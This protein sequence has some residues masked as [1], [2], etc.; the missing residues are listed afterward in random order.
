MRFLKTEHTFKRLDLVEADKKKIQ[1]S[2]IKYTKSFYN[3]IPYKKISYSRVEFS[4]LEEF[5]NEVKNKEENQII[6]QKLCT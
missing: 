3:H 5:E 4:V 6:W 1:L 2:F